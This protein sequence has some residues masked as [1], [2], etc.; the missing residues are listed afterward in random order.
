[1]H[2]CLCLCLCVQECIRVCTSASLCVHKLLSTS[3]CSSASV[4]LCAHLHLFLSLSLCKRV[5]LSMCL[6]MCVP[7]C[8][9]MRTRVLEVS[10]PILNYKICNLSRNFHLLFSGPFCPSPDLPDASQL[11]YSPLISWELVAFQSQL[12]EGCALLQWT[13]GAGDS[14]EHKSRKRYW[15]FRP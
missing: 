9:C 13:L 4:S 12:L 2:A 1:M 10:L 3:A 7:V 6:C 14:F 11:F 15:N 8:E 5:S